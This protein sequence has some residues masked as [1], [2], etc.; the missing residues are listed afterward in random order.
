LGS[1][2]AFLDL[3]AIGDVLAKEDFFLVSKAEVN[4]A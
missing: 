4:F 2:Y 1:A 3:G